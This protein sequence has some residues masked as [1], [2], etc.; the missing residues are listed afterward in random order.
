M[1]LL[2]LILYIAENDCIEPIKTVS[3]DRGADQASPNEAKYLV[4]DDY[5]SKT[6]KP[7]KCVWTVQTSAGS[8]IQVKI[9]E[10]N[11]PCQGGNF[12]IIKES[13]MESKKICGQP[14]KQLIVST[15]EEMTFVLVIPKPGSRGARVK[16]GFIQVGEMKGLTIEEFNKGG[17]APPP[18]KPKGKRPMPKG[19]SP[20]SPKKPSPKKPKRPDK[21]YTGYA[22]KSTKTKTVIGS[23]N[24]WEK[25]DRKPI[26]VGGGIIFL[27][28]ILGGAFYIG[29]AMMNDK[30]EQTKLEASGENKIEKF[31]IKEPEVNNDEQPMVREE[32]KDTQFTSIT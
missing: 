15:S 21:P 14:P 9:P 32:S 11:I 19:K 29:R 23:V 2:I 13:G 7:S 4:L 28:L 30:I 26:L 31:E 3:C 6:M 16:I 24:R 12:L 8:H 20:K 17:K 1:I 10:L 27:L 25:K 18:K 22:P 5:P